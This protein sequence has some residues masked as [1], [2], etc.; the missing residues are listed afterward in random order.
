MDRDHRKTPVRHRGIQQQEARVS[1]P[2]PWSEASED[3]VSALNVNLCDG[4]SI[5]DANRRL[6]V[7]GHNQLTSTKPR[8]A[9]AILVDQFRSLVVLLLLGAA[10]VAFAFGEFTE[11][12]AIAAVV[13]FNSAIGFITE[14]RAVRSMEALRRLGRV[15]ATV[16]R[17][18]RVHSVI[19]EQ[20]VPGD[21]VLFDAGD[22]VAADVRIIEASKLEADESTLTGESAPRYQ[23]S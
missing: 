14:L 12:I 20:L 11:A 9:L 5:A 13:V 16:R 23:K 1:L 21:I 10:G 18:G 19:A 2:T 7:Y 3:L 4:L 17:G 22:I 6:A 15:T 8:K